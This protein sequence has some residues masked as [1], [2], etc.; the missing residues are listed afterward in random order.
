MRH[1][2]MKKL[3]LAT[4]AVFM[5]MLIQVG[6]ANAAAAVGLNPASLAFGNQAVGTTSA[7]RTVILTN[8]GDTTLNITSITG[9]GDF[10]VTNACGATLAVGG[11]CTIS[12]TFSPTAAGN[13]TGQITVTTDAASSPDTVALSGTGTGG[14]AVGLNPASLAFGNQAVGTTSAVR[15]VILT[16]TGDTT[17]NIT[18]I[19]GSGDFSVTNACG[20][21]L[22][23]GGSCTIS[24]TFSP[25]AAGNRTGQ[26]TVTTDAAS[27]PDTVALSGTGTGGPAVGLN[28]ASLAF[29]NQAVGTTSAVRTVIL[30]NTGDTTLNITSITGSGDFSVTNACGATLAVGGSCTISVTFS[31][32]AA[33]NRTGQITVTTDAASSPDTVALSGT[34]TGGP[35]VGLNPASLAFGNQAVGTTSAVRTVILTNTGD[36]TL[37]ITSITGSGDFSVTNACGATLAVGGSCTI[38]VTFSPTAAGNRT[39]QITVT[40]DAASSP[41]T[42]ALSGTGT[43]GPAVGL[44]PAS[45]AFGNQAV[46]TTSAVRTVILTNTGDTTLN[47]TSITGSGDFSVTNA[48]GATLAVGGSCTISVTFSPTAAGN[49]TGQITVTTDAV[50]SPDTVALSGTGTGAPIP[51]LNEWGMII[52][53]LLL[54]GST[55]FAIRRRQSALC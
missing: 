17:L 33:G 19:T 39:G 38:S 22:A 24:V 21:T 53:S 52:F 11:S 37:N 25:T 41:D 51:T 16:N 9:S 35:A 27:S 5:F 18:S 10:S 1:S 44:N 55:Y 45:L 8:T 3:I 14:P 43:G 34:G 32:T 46:G 26:I 15:T 50:S 2:I 40:T 4:P 47:I 49:R 42:V 12:V 13:R 31:P 54:A 7:V 48:C 20:A 28:P 6:L 30:T 23:V 29:G 36:T